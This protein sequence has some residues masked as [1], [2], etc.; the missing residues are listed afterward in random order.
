MVALDWELY[1]EEK[2]WLKKVASWLN[3]ELGMFKRIIEI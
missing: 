2:I 1:S 3:A